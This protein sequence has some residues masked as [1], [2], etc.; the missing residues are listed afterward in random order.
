MHSR[1]V[2]Y[3][4]PAH[5]PRRADDPTVAH[6]VERATGEAGGGGESHACDGEAAVAVEGDAVLLVTRQRAAA[7]DDLAAGGIR[8]I[9]CGHGGR[10]CSN[11]RSSDSNDSL[12]F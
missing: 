3:K 10:G 5:G 1:A 6:K 4:H 12:A 2:V 7:A 11:V 8:T 9:G